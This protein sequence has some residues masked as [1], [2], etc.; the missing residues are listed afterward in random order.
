MRRLVIVVGALLVAS[1]AAAQGPPPSPSAQDDAIGIHEVKPGETLMSITASYLGSP[2]A[3]KENW[4]LNPDLA[5][6]HALT[7]GQ[8]I[9]VIT[10]M[11]AR[12]AEVAAVARRVEEKPHPD[13]WRVAKVGSKLKEHDGLRT[14]E[15]SS[16]ELR[17]D[18]GTRL[19]VGEQSM[20]FLRESGVATTRT[21]AR[22]ALEIVDGQADLE[23]P[24]PSAGARAQIEIRVAD[25]EARPR[26]EADE[27]PRA[28][29]RRS[30]DGSAQVM[31]FGGAA[32]VEAEGG[33]VEVAKGMGTSVP[34]GGR[35]LPP[36]A[37]LPA[38]RPKVL[39]NEKIYDHANP[40]FRWAAVEG[41]AAYVVEVC[42]DLACA[43][44]LDR[45][46]GLK[47]T[48][49]TAEGLPLGAYHWRVSAVSPSGLDGF[50]STPV[51]FTIK[52]LWRRPPERSPDMN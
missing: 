30:R 44:L 48:Q 5:D 8:K 32:D 11:K 24:P 42:R 52:G 7:P 25:A 26:A 47:A 29:A 4:R 37:L 6:P 28:R 31:V 16:S 14:Y 45:G 51:E 41:A 18:D 34:K 50:P 9:R 19:I 2:N 46:A 22:R 3:W 38:P 43:E 1:P 35:P 23:G 39:S 21:V 17:F 40:T 10:R 36:E 20:V 15:K 49:W 33:R 27:A 12:T 13:P